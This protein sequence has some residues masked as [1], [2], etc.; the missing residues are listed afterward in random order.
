MNSTQPNY[1]SP[2]PETRPVE[3]SVNAATECMGRAEYLLER[4]H[5]AVTG[6]EPPPGVATG[7]G[8]AGLM[9]DADRLASRMEAYCADLERTSARITA[10]N[11]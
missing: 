5:A 4:L 1:T 2:P 11:V 3:Q 9:H 6:D 10:A 7:G 8:G